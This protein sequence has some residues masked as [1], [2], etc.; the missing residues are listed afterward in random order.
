MERVHR[1]WSV[2]FGR[3]VPIARSNSYLR[4]NDTKPT[5]IPG[6]REAVVSYSSDGGVTWSLVYV[7]SSAKKIN[8]LGALDSNHFWAAGDGG[9]ILRLTA[10]TKTH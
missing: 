3:S 6:K 5:R 8:A 10:T 7:N 1:V 4:L 2:V 9:L